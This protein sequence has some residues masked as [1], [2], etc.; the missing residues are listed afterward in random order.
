MKRSVISLGCILALFL[1]EGG[2]HPVYASGETT[3]DGTSVAL[4]NES[5]EPS[6]AEK[7]VSASPAPS[8]KWRHH[9]LHSLSPSSFE[10]GAQ[11]YLNFLEETQ[12]PE[13]WEI[14]DFLS[15]KNDIIDLFIKN[16]IRINDLAAQ[17][18]N[19]IDNTDHYIVWRDY[20]IQKLSSLIASGRLS[21]ENLSAAVSK[22]DQYAGGKAP[23]LTGTALISAVKLIRNP[24]HAPLV[25]GYLDQ[26]TLAEYAFKCAT[27]EEEPYIDRITA[28][29]IAAE[30]E[31]PE[32]AAYTRSIL[33]E[34]TSGVPVM[35]KVSSIAAL[36]QTGSS[37]DIPLLTSYRNS[38][39]IRIRK[40]ARHSIDRIYNN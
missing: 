16:R 17:L 38:P 13:G 8:F 15:L 3:D 36:G 30:L 10:S 28:L 5:Y 22:L 2:L 12:Y 33:D 34:R 19:V 11:C 27:G 29:Q 37:A 1:Q 39:D 31:H 35:F 32:V 14:N 20:C 7:I 9:T 24:D 4:G 25:S 23:G 6:V 40:A 26:D 21:P 18:L